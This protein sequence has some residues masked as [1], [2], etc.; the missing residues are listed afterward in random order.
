MSLDLYFKSPKCHACGLAQDSKHFNYT[1]NVNKMWYAA[2]PDW[3]PGKDGHTRM[4]QV[5]GMT[6]AESLPLLEAAWKELSLNSGK[7]QP[8]E[9]VNGWGSY[10]GF[11]KWVCQLREAALV[12][13]DWIWSGCR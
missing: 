8:M 5:D 9:P 2:A 13:P 10:K 11:V 1:Y 12:H 7:Y 3:P 6:G 4:V